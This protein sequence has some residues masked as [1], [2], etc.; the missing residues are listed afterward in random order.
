MSLAAEEEPALLRLRAGVPGATTAASARLPL[1]GRK[2][3]LVIIDEQVRHGVLARAD[4]ETIAEAAS[5]S[6]SERLPLVI[7][8]ASAGADV[9]EGVSSLDG[10]GRA[11]RAMAACSGVV[12]VVAVVY[13]TAVSGTALL[14]GL[15]DAVV[16]TPEAVAFVS[17]PAAVAQV[18]GLQVSSAQLGGSGVHA[19][20]SGVTT[21]A[22]P[23]LQAALESVATF[24]DH[25]PDHVDEEPP[26]SA[27]R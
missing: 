4:S 16:M 24:L 14:L 6:L 1:T 25:L 15:A 23:D 19:R 2:V 11:A 8:M 9:A 13:G 27:R 21:L 12:P 18:T 17:G 26:R 10:W 5:T 22:A 20:V 3:V 7:V